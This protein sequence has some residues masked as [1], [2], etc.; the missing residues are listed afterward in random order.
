[1]TSMLCPVLVS[2]ST[3][4]HGLTSLIAKTG[5]AGRRELVAHAAKLTIPACNT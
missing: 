3:E 1:M 4:L 2:R 5:Q